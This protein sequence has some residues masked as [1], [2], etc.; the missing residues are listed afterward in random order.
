MRSILIVD[1]SAWVI[2]AVVSLM[3][4]HGYHATPARH[5]KEAL[6]RLAESRYDAVITDLEMPEMDGFQ[7][8]GEIR[9]ADKYTPVIVLSG[10]GDV[11]AA[12]GA[13]REGADDYVQKSAKDLTGTLPFVVNRAIERKAA[14]RRLAIYESLLPIC[15]HCKRIR[16]ESD[17]EEQAWV[18]IEEYFGAK[19]SGIGFSHGICPECMQKYHPDTD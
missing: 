7:L 4:P 17:G 12:V 9:K 6:M 13:M 2:T 8:I 3:E 11:D 14:E 1:D 15:M 5:G 16:N 19:K 10:M 18:G